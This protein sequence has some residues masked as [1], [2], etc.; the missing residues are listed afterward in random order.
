[1]R[2]C[3]LWRW[4]TV[5]AA[6]GLV[7]GFWGCATKREGADRLAA[8]TPR[9]AA[10][11]RFL[12]VDIRTV[13]PMADRVF[14]EYFRVEAASANRWISRPVEVT[15]PGQTGRVRD[16]LTAFPNRRR[17]LAELWLTRQGPHVVA[18]CCVQTQRLDTTERAAFDRERGDDRPTDTPIDRAG[19]GSTTVREEWVRIGRDRQTENLILSVIEQE[20]AATRP[21]Q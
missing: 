4:A 21:A 15:R 16:V 1:M 2:A 17:R 3:G 19:A 7:V 14:R 18:C 12:N 11:R 20:L 13:Q 9:D 5:F 8:R 6:V 10:S